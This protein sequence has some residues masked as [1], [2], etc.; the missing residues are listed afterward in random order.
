MQIRMQVQVLYPTDRETRH[1][2]T[3]K[4]YN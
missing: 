2:K 4:L 3:L 1:C